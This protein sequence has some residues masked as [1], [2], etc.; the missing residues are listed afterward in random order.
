MKAFSVFILCT[1]TAHCSNF[2]E[3]LEKLHKPQDSEGLP[4][5]GCWNLNLDIFS[6]H[7]SQNSQ[8][9][10]LEAQNNKTFKIVRANSEDKKRKRW[11]LFSSLVVECKEIIT[12]ISNWKCRNGDKRNTKKSWIFLSSYFWSWHDSTF[13]NLNNIGSPWWL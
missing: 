2:A 13:Q 10:K 12:K 8:S 1:S 4:N 7:S 6:I 5:F 9:L 3:N 11:K